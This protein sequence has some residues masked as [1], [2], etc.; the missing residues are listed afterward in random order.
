MNFNVY[1]FWYCFNFTNCTNWSRFLPLLYTNFCVLTCMHV[2]YKYVPRFLHWPS[3]KKMLVKCY[4]VLDVPHDIYIYHCNF[5]SQCDVNYVFN[6]N[7]N[8]T[9]SIV[10]L[11]ASL[12]LS[13]PPYSHVSCVHVDNL[14]SLYHNFGLFR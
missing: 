1:Y 5:S 4:H 2:S 6:F 14:D 12:S 7:A 3:N 10:K 11:L 9:S 13:S 8:E